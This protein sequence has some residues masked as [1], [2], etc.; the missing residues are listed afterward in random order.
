MSAGRETPNPAG[1]A[2]PLPVNPPRP[3]QYPATTAPA[4]PPGRSS[5]RGT[6]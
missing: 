2:E 3:R 6:T 4:Q 5:G 1:R